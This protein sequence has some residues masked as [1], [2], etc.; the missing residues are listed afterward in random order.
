MPSIL[1]VRYSSCPAFCLDIHAFESDLALIAVVVGRNPTST[2]FSMTWSGI[3]LARSNHARKKE[4]ASIHRLL[5]LCSGH[6]LTAR[7][8]QR[9]FIAWLTAFLAIRSDAW[10][11]GIVRGH[12]GLCVGTCDCA[13]ACG[14]VRGHVGLYVD[15]MKKRI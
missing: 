3:K 11:C 8:M 4:A 1:R 9:A 10:A 12:V 2:P 13:W 7:I 14:I 6:S 5:L 15:I